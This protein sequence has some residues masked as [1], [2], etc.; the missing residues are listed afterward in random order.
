[1][2]LFGYK[3]GKMKLEELENVTLECS[4]DELL[5]VIEFLQYSARLSE[6]HGEDFGHV[7]FKDWCRKNDHKPQRDLIVVGKKNGNGS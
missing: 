7:H 3:K 4:R 1:M 5:K 6:V 2:N